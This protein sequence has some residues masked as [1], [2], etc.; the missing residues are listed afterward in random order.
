MP[1]ALLPR[2]GPLSFTR[3]GVEGM[4]RRNNI[5]NWRLL[6]S[7]FADT[8]PASIKVS[9]TNSMVGSQGVEIRLAFLFRGAHVGLSVGAL[10]RLVFTPDRVDTMLFERRRA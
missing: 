8:T 4:Y 7:F 5:I 10:S 6:G 1:L 2:D 3:F 9:F